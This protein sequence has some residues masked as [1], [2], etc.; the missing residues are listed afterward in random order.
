[1][2]K[3]IKEDSDSEDEK[4]QMKYQKSNIK[5]IADEVRASTKKAL[6]HKEYMKKANEWS[7][8]YQTPLVRFYR[9][10]GYPSRKSV[11]KSLRYLKKNGFTEKDIKEHN[12]KKKVP[13]LPDSDNDVS[14]DSEE[15]SSSEEEYQSK[16]KTRGKSVIQGNG[17][18]TH[19]QAHKLFSRY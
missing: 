16:R 7:E 13:P 3:L 6:E 9:N 19:E 10:K 4:E 18:L 2:P 12:M 17:T 14:S 11:V 1:M 8:K 5:S 15:E